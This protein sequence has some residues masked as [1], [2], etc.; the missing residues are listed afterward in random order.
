MVDIKINKQFP[1]FPVLAECVVRNVA[2]YF[3]TANKMEES[4][5]SS[6]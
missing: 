3:V 5:P 2:R 6:P 1:Q 4:T